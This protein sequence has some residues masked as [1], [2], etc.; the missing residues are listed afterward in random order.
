MSVEESVET[1][2]APFDGI[3]PLQRAHLEL[4]RTWGKEGRGKSPVSV[5]KKVHDFMAAVQITGKA[6]DR[7]A[8]RD[9]AQAVLDYWAIELI[10]TGDETAAGDETTILE[11][12]DESAAPD[13][14]DKSSPFKGLAAFA[15][16]DAALFFGREQAKNELAE[17]VRKTPFVVVSGPSGSGKSSLIQAG[18]IPRLRQTMARAD[19]QYDL[20]AVVTPG[21]R[22]IAALLKSLAPSLPPDEL[23]ELRT[24]L[25]K[26]PEQIIEIVAQHHQKPVILIVDQ[27]EEI[28]TLQEDRQEEAHGFVRALGKLAQESGERTHRVVIG[29]RDDYLRQLA[30]L[31]P[32]SALMADAA[33]QFAPRPLEPRQIKVAIERPA[34]AVGL[35]F[36]PGLVEELVRDVAGEAAALPLL[37]FTLNQLWEKKRRN[38]VTAEVAAEVGSPREALK[39]AA[40]KVIASLQLLQ[41]EE[42]ARRL[43]LKLVTPKT[44][45][46]FLRHPRTREFLWSN[47]SDSAAVDRV[48]ERFVDAG[49]LRKQ[50]A[51]DDEK[52][53]RFDVAHEALIRNWPWLTRLLQSEWR[54]HEK[55]WRL[56]SQAKLW[57]DSGFHVDYLLS[58]TALGDARA[59][60]QRSA[61]LDELIRKSEQA[62]E[63]KEELARLG[64]LRRVKTKWI[65][66]LAGSIAS[67]LVIAFGIWTVIQQ[68]HLKEIENQRDRQDSLLTVI[69]ELKESLKLAEDQVEVSNADKNKIASQLNSRDLTALR[70]FL[71]DIGVPAPTAEALV[72]G[73][74]VAVTL[75]PE[76]IKRD[77]A[78]ERSSETVQQSG[79]AVVASGGPTC[80]GFIWIGRPEGSVISSF[81][82]N[83]SDL[84]GRSFNI[85]YDIR[86]RKT[87]PSSAYVMGEPMGIVPTGTKLVADGVPVAYSRSSGEQYWVGVAAPVEVCTKVF[88]QFAG[89]PSR[90][91]KLGDDIKKLGYQVPPAQLIATA[92][93]KAEVRY[94]Y[95]SDKEIA[96][97]LAKQLTSQLPKTTI[98]PES[99]VNFKFTKPPQ[100]TLEAWIDLPAL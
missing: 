52:D 77:E 24:Q 11:P 82:S 100:G 54:E 60:P 59:F 74:D 58:G 64:E 38:R 1:R 49:L 56:Q 67:M 26:T 43:F 25:F 83:P 5:R 79:R 81:P 2:V 48:L 21:S 70:Q 15:E 27:F 93:D 89:D 22:P 10:P 85:N 91:K 98:K 71:R 57:S 41:N 80:S 76:Q 7:P 6:L 18:L 30:S 92:K 34:E 28:F 14:S 8:D 51:T 20:P 13:L 35:R 16:Q 3:V 61:E 44:E 96:E 42:I 19:G 33:S 88:I 36:D 45:N 65:G 86:L 40:D 68:D 73:P 66:I 31:E 39:R 12:F 53:D 4:L 62:E 47:E 32:L 90:A 29:I 55:L 94:F 72:L 97:K 87:L 78:A 69:S 17:R 95:D 75:T 9:A 50:Q 46:E 84:K 99:L 63:E 37:Q 23:A